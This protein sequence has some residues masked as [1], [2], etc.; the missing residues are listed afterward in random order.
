MISD[1]QVSQWTASNAIPVSFFAIRRT[2]GISALGYDSANKIGWRRAM[3]TM[4]ARTEEGRVSCPGP[5]PKSPE[6][7]ARCRACGKCGALARLLSAAV[8]NAARPHDIS[9]VAFASE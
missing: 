9:H 8:A 1:A 5:V 3:T 6:H 4:L 2:H 7:A